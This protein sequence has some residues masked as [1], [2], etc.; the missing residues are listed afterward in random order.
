M[1]TYEELCDPIVLEQFKNSV[2]DHIATYINESKVKTASAAA[3]L[4]DEYVLTHSGCSAIRRYHG[5]EGRR[6]N[7]NFRHGKSANTQESGQVNVRN[8]PG[9]DGKFDYSNLSCM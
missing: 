9:T 5:D 3:V 2:P 1:Y 7:F 8:V 6:E 4:A